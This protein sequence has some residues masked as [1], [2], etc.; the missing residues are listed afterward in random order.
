[1]HE[2]AKVSREE[3]ARRQR[4]LDQTCVELIGT[5]KERN[6]QSRLWIVRLLASSFHTGLGF[7]QSPSLYTVYHAMYVEYFLRMRLYRG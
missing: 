2:A 1:M 6:V 7:L 3:S 5:G 4:A